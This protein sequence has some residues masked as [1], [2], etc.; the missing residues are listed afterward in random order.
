MV[1]TTI[2]TMT[3]ENIAED[4]AHRVIVDA[5]RRTE[6]FIGVI[7]TGIVAIAGKGYP[8]YCTALRFIEHCR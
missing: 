5:V 2:V 1:V 8:Q 3:T 6:T 7:G 4:L